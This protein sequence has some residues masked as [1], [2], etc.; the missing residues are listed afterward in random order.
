MRSDGRL[1]GVL[2]ISVTLAFLCGCSKTCDIDC[3]GTKAAELKIDV[4]KTTTSAGAGGVTIDGGLNVT[5]ATAWQR[6]ECRDPRWIQVVTTNAP[7]GGATSPYVDPADRP[8]AAP[9]YW[10]DTAATSGVGYAITSH[11]NVKGFVLHFE[12][13]PRRR[14]GP[15]QNIDWKAE[16]CLVCPGGGNVLR[17]LVCIKYGFSI[18]ENEVTAADLECSGRASAGFKSTVTNNYAGYS[19]R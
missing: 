18:R 11:R 12:D 7:L 8:D 17:D 2:L 16:L 10:D 9:F 4:Y 14:R 5:D 1:R 6:C 15:G 19:F 13:S 3:G